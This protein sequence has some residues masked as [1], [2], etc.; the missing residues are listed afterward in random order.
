MAEGLPRTDSERLP[1]AAPTRC[2]QT[3]AAFQAVEILLQAAD[4]AGRAAGLY[5]S[6][7][8]VAGAARAEAPLSLEAAAVQLQ[9]Y[10]LPRAEAG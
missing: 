7:A 6:W 4:W 9:L 5:R 8:P 1:A 3:G 10:C 2:P